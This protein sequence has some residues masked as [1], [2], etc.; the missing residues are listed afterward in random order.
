MGK[1]KQLKALRSAFGVLGKKDILPFGRYK[2]C[3][4]SVVLSINVSYLHWLINNT[5]LV[6]TPNVQK[7][8]YEGHLKQLAANYRHV[9]RHRGSY[10]YCDYDDYDHDLISDWGPDEF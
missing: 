10:R 5:S 9:P 1:N 2:G 6:F 7:L 3:T 4:V 8:A